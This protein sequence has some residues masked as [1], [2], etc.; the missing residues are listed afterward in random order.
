MTQDQEGS[1]IDTQAEISQDENNSF[2]SIL[3]NIDYKQEVIRILTRVKAM[4][5]SPKSTWEK[6]TTED[7]DIKDLY[8]QY[9]IP[10]LAVSI[11]SAFIGMQVF[12]ISIPMFGNFRPPFFSALFSTIVHFVLASL[13]YLLAALIISKISHR[14]AGRSRLVDALKLLTFAAVPFL[15]SGV[16]QLVPVLSFVTLFFG[17]YTLYVYYLGI[18][19]M[20]DVPEGK[21]FVFTVVSLIVIVIV[22]M[23]VGLLI[24]TVFSTA[25]DFGQVPQVDK[26]QMINDLMKSIQ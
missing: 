6:I 16:F 12:G 5:V 1:N 17:L 13:S 2:A 19:P 15:A 20:L 18:C 4:L 21:R 23:I 25:P 14:F 9:L 10:L 22:F 11:F 8:Q 26:Q 7:L 24:G 3:K